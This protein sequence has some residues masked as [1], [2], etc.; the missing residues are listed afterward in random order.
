M[1]MLLVMIDFFLKKYFL[2]QSNSFY[3]K[4]SRKFQFK[5]YLCTSLLLFSNETY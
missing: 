4:E 2:L 3:F 5:K 1:L